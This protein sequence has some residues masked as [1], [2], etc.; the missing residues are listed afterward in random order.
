MNV[1]LAPD[2]FK[3]CMSATDAASAMARGV[4]AASQRLGRPVSVDRCPVSDGGAG[5]VDAL[6]T[7][8]SGQRRTTTVTGPLGD[9]VE[10]AWGWIKEDD[11]TAVIEM[12]AAAG[13]P[14]V[15]V[16][17][18]DPERTTTY[19]VGELIRAALDAGAG[20]IILGIGNSATCD[21]GAG[22]ASALGAAFL[23][24]RGDLIERPSGG[25]LTRLGRIE[26]DGL[27]ERLGSTE[28]LVAC[29]VDNPLF[30]PEGSAAVYGPQ[31]GA[32]RKQVERLDQALRRLANCAQ[33]VGVQVDAA[34]PGAGAAG[35]VGFGLMAFCR[36]Q[37]RR[38]VDLV[39]RAADFTERA[40]RADLV[41]TGEGRLDAQSLRGK[42]TIG[43]ARAASRT[44]TRVIALVGSC[45]QGW[46]AATEAGG[47]P[48]ERV[49]RITPESM[50]TDEALEAGPRL[51]A[52]ATESAVYDDFSGRSVTLPESKR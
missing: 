50:S 34:A 47:G 52:A 13:L 19:G 4:E 23:D 46:E 33:D 49:V 30:G 42:A 51:L 29:D 26:L 6:L 22:M 3:E 21:G 43:V 1:L 9:P 25:D 40:G 24:E 8:K 17:R 16:D 12:S 45:G 44:G 14:L 11:G 36:G 41:L 15:P 10:A 2:A 7:A 35:G 5:L 37:L 31:K 39:L 27:D 28:I 38:G 20:R 18:R 48:V 32:S